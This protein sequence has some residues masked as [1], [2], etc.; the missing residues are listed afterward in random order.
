MDYYN[1]PDFSRIVLGL[2]II[3]LC[4]IPFAIWKII[5]LMI[6]TFSHIKII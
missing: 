1:F 5:E 4:L 2:F 6:V 3:I